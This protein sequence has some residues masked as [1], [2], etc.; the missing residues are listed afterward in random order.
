MKRL[1]ITGSSGFIGQHLVSQLQCSDFEIHTP[2]SKELNLL[3]PLAV[4][5]FMERTR[6]T[7]LVHLAWITTPGVFFESPENMRWVE[8]TLRLAQAFVES[9]GKRFIG[10]GTC[11]ETVLA[12]SP[13]FY[14]ICKNLTREL[15]QAYFAKTGVGF[16]WGRIFFLYGPGEKPE[17]LIPSIIRGLLAGEEV[18]CGQGKV[19]RDYLYVEDC[20]ACFVD[21]MTSAEQGVFDIVSGKPIQLSELILATAH[22]LGRP[23]LIKL[24]GRS[25]RVGEPPVIVSRQTL[26]WQPKISLSEGM[27]RTIERWRYS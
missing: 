12:E 15:L 7:H 8:A 4:Q 20:A 3:D 25:D 10:A 17:R 21:L 5:R 9:G 19:V 23:E 22:T 26:K 2:S 13:T 11:F 6:P 14:G 16:A 27:R 1:L 18:L 24:G